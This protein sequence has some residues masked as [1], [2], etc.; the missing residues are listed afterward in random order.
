M[1]KQWTRKILATAVTITIGLAGATSSY[2]TAP[3][4]KSSAEDLL[5]IQVEEQVTGIIEYIHD[6]EVIIKGT[7]GKRYQVFLHQYKSA[8]IKQLGLLEGAEVF[9]EG[10]FVS[11]E[12]LQSF[13]YYKV[14]MPED[15]SEADV[16]QLEKLFNEAKK[17]E[18]MEQYEQAG[19]VWEEMYKILQPYYIAMWEP[20]SFVAPMKKFAFVIDTDVIA[21]Q[22]II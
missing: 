7:D 21:K 9:I 2:A 12:E 18:Q 22:E 10:Q 4:M 1:K 6:K 5:K 19:K 11:H 16:D 13:E 15:V 14:H 8:E 20:E 3:V 17:F